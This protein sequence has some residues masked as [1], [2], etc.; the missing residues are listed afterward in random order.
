[1]K[2]ID[3]PEFREKPGTPAKLD[4]VLDSLG[5]GRSG[6]SELQSQEDL[7]ASLEKT[8]DNRF[9]LLRNVTLED[10]DTP[11]PL[12]LLGPSG[13][14]V[15]FPSPARGVFRAKEETLEYMDEYNRVY[16][17]ANPNLLARTIMMAKS[18]EAYLNSNFPAPIEVEPVLYF[19]DP[20]T[21]VES[22]RPS[23]RILLVD[24]LERFIAGQLQAAVLYE[25]EEVQK[26]VD[27]LL[28][29]S[30]I[31]ER[32]VSPYPER[33]AFSF[34]DESGLDKPSIA[35]RLP[36]G[37]G[38]VSALNK[39]PFSGRQWLLLGCM[40][41]VNVVVLIAFVLLVLFTS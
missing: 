15:I 9:V 32:Q 18:A 6:S 10:L 39:I 31:T 22:V 4:S 24:G 20:G 5:M 37:E 7:I 21:H 33:D 13:V 12:V 1:M 28:K 36:R 26:L 11:I 19:S 17:Q 34:V 41:V 2:V 8:L 38:I 27:L 14:S 40:V 29:A 3:N 16:R 23:L 25:R 30:R 35:D